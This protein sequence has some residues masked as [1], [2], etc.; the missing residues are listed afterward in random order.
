MFRIRSL[1]TDVARAYQAGE[2]DAYGRAPERAV[3][4]GG[5]N[6]CRHCFTEIADGEA[7]LILAHRPFP[8]TQPYAETGPIFLCAEPCRAWRGEGVPALFRNRDEILM[9]G[10]SADNR[11]VYGTGKV[12]PTTRIA[13][14]AQELLARA[15]VAF[16]HLR[17]ATENC[18]HAR[19][20]RS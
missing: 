6:P 19:I 9:R 4:D 5:G 15:D 14:R 16:L 1:P 18:Y 7:M 10:Y 13:E 20:E 2:P 12:I 17:S 3:S 8:D 11:I